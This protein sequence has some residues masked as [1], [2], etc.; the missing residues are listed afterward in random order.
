MKL[1]AFI[2]IVTLTVQSCT[3]TSAETG[4]ITPGAY[5]MEE[6][7]PRIDGLRVGVVVNQ[8]SVVGDAHLVDTLL[9]RGVNIRRIFTPEHGFRGNADAGAD[10]GDGSYSSGNIPVV[11]LYGNKRKPSSDDLKD[12]DVILFDL[13]DVG[14][15]FFTYIS[16]LHYCMEAC[17]EEDVELIVLDR[18]NPNGHY[19][20]GP[21]LEPEFKSFVGMHPVPVVYGLTIG[22]YAGMIN[23]EDWLTNSLQCSLSVVKCSHYDHTS[24]YTL[25]VWPSPNL[26]SMRAIY[27][28][29][30]TA[31]FEGTIASE[32]RGTPAPFELIGHPDYP[33]KTVCFIP[34]PVPGASMDPKLKGKACYGIDLRGLPFESLQSAATLDLSYLIRFYSAMKSKNGFFIEYFN[35]LAGNK[36]LR[37]QIEKG[38]SGQEIRE[39]WQEALGAYKKIRIKYLLYPDFK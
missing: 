27:L 11:S 37:E 5:R 32:G 38:M 19:V 25:P 35:L 3:G 28:Y 21:V 22:E 39:S 8:T 24:L 10:V 16:T 9:A 2:G 15:R 23:G 20:D 29:P 7:L 18:P 12:L 6:Y 36:T 30:S 17:A 34:Q 14:V 13:Q 33:D 26:S 31:F 4:D 1:Y